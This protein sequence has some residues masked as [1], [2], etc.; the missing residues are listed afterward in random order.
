MKKNQNRY[1]QESLSPTTSY[2]V[3]TIILIV[4]LF[5]DNLFKY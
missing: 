3:I 5:A 4:A 1:E 2:I